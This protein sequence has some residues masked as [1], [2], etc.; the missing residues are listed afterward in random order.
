M[1]IC[2]KTSFKQLNVETLLTGIKTAKSLCDGTESKSARVFRNAVILSLGG[3]SSNITVK[4]FTNGT[5]HFTGSTTVSECE[6]AAKRVSAALDIIF[7]TNTNIGA[8]TIQMINTSFKIRSSFHLENAYA[9]M[10]NSCN[11]DPTITIVY[12]K[13]RYAGLKMYMFCDGKKTTGLLFKSGSVI[14]TGLKDFGEFARCIDK[15]HSI[16]KPLS[17]SC[18]R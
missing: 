7:D 14:L 3:Y 11:N 10:N 2:Y 8:P 13:E 15:I 17:Q 18:I 6:R 16:I 1:T 5:F 12:D 4:V 9:E